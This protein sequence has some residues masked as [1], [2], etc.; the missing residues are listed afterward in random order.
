[1]GRSA[2]IMIMGFS[3]A[4]LMIGS[5]ITRV[6]STAMESY[7]HYY[8]SS[9]AHAMAGSAINLAARSLFADRSWRSGISNKQFSGGVVNC[10]LKDT[11]NQRVRMTA[12]ATFQG[13]SQVVSCLLQP[14]SFSR[15]AYYTISDASGYWVTGDTCWG[16]LH[17]NDKLNVVGYPVFMG[18]A[19]TLNGL[20]RYRNPQNNSNTLDKPVFKQG[21]QQGVN[22]ALPNDLSLLKSAAQTGGKIINGGTGD[23]FIEFLSNGKL[24]WKQGGAWG[25]GAGW[26]TDNINDVTPN[27]AFYVDGKDIH[28]KGTVHGQLTVG[29][30]QNIW[31]DN[32]VVYKDDPR[33]GPSTDMLGLV[34]GQTLWITDN[35]DNRGP[36]NDFI[37][38]A[39][40]FSRTDGL[41]VQNYSSGPVRGRLTTVGSQ[42]AKVGGYTGQFSGDPPIII[43]GY[44]PGGTYYD[45]RLMLAA[46]PYFPTT[47]QYEIISWFE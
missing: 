11:T 36:N 22:V 41:W 17:V 40:V 47:G 12:T 35:A 4:L 7:T 10:T 24:K 1:M 14:S 15:F 20:H 21:F 23:V 33:Y 3:T 13:V 39:C 18:K 46:P 38:M 28:V 45:E 29:T 8:Q 25:D 32:D 31:L 9:V 6:S 34:A 42:V 43:H 26:N 27:G 44:A 16:P 37:L 2:L 5:N 30:N 19:T